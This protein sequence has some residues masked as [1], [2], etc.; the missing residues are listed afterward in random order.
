MGAGL[1]QTNNQNQSHGGSV[2]ASEMWVGLSSGR[3]D[4]I[5]VWYAGLEV[6]RGCEGGYY[7][8]WMAV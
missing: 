3:G 7:W 8:S 5:G 4:P 1:D 2:L 6:V